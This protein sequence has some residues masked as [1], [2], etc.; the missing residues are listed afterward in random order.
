M[1]PKIQQLH[2]GL[3]LH[4]TSKTQT[5]SSEHNLF[6]AGNP[7]HVNSLAL[8]QIMF[9]SAFLDRQ[10]KS[11]L[12]LR[13][14]LSSTPELASFTISPTMIN[15]NEIFVE[16]TYEVDSTRS[17]LGSHGGFFEVLS[18]PNEEDHNIIEKFRRWFNYYKSPEHVNEISDHDFNKYFKFMKDTR[19]SSF[20]IRRLELLSASAASNRGGTMKQIGSDIRPLDLEDS[21]SYGIFHNEKG[22]QVTIYDAVVIYN[23]VLSRKT[24][25]LNQSTLGSFKRMVRAALIVADNFPLYRND[26]SNC[27]HFTYNVLRVLLDMRNG[28][29]VA[30]NESE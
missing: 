20:I 11:G 13:R 6:D 17:K 7:S 2:R 24:F 22:T 8:L 15:S 12:E 28:I 4:E 27:N 18:K 25:C 30:R 19:L 3:S 10:Q 14:I 23:R 1:P 21:N 29:D 5:G 26:L 9:R 16:V